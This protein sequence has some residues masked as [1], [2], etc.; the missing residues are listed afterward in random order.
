MTVSRRSLLGAAVVSAAASATLPAIAS[1]NTE[2]T[3]A[4]DRYDRLAEAINNYA[5]Q[6]MLRAHDRHMST[7]NT[8][9][10]YASSYSNQDA[11]EQQLDA[12]LITE[13][14]APFKDHGGYTSY[15]IESYS[16]PM[17]KERFSTIVRMRHGNAD[18][19]ILRNYTDLE[20]RVSFGRYAY[21][22]Y[23]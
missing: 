8:N 13:F 1:D 4:P 22:N 6:V 12:V 21:H 5:S 18:A 19:T 9:H 2:K 3:V 23:V 17:S 10:E 7:F 11:A 15:Q 20:I 16:E 14:A